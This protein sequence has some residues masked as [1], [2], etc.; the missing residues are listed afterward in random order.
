MRHHHQKC[1]E[2]YMNRSNKWR[3]ENKKYRNSRRKAN[4]DKTKK[5]RNNREW[6]EYEVLMLL[7]P[8]MGHDREL[9]EHFNRSVQAIQSKRYQLK[10]STA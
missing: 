10:R 2:V 3:R 5:P 4:Y 1:L 9:A 6:T 7:T 8:S